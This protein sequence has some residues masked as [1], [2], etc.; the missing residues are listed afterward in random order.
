MIA[1]APV[2]GEPREVV[3]APP[4]LAAYASRLAL[5]MAGLLLFALGSAWTY[6]AHIGLGPWDCFHLGLH[7]H[8]PITQ[9][10]AGILTGVVIVLL[11]LLL[12]IRPGTGTLCNMVFVGLFFDA[13]NTVLPDGGDAGLGWQLVLDVLGVLVIGLG[14]GLYIKANLGA[15]P[16]DSLMLALTRRSGRRVSLVR[17]GV[18]LSALTFGFL[19]GGPVGAGTLGYALGVG[20]ARSA[21]GSSA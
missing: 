7:L 4:G 3:V 8:L 16:R 2:T 21:F 1:P 20:P 14:S 10:Q 12:G 6:K 13:W 19:L 11:S 15:G 17:A 18:E 9:G 5:L